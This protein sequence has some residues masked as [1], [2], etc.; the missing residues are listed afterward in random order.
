M[1]G[2]P[3]R[4]ET[5]ERL[6]LALTEGGLQRMAARVLAAFLF[7]EEPTVTAGQLAYELDASPGSVSGAIKMLTSVGLIERVPAPGSR[8]EHYRMRDDAW[9]TLFTSQNIIMGRMR[10]AADAGIAATEKRSLAR[11]RLEQMRDFYA[12][13]SSEL[14]ALLARW[15]Q[16]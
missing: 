7:T 14:P 2:T 13:L 8:R 5:A 11:Q 4:R 3:D 15:R 6:A 10:E 9:A 12:F 1:S 16:R